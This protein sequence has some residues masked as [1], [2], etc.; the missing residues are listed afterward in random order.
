MIETPP[1]KVCSKCSVEK[2][3]SDYYSRSSNGRKYPESRC[4][5]C[6]I[7]RTMERLK[8]PEY[9]ARH[10]EYTKTA[11]DR[12]HAREKLDRKSGD[13]DRI[14]PHMHKDIKNSDR[15]KGREFD[16]TVDFIAESLKKPCSYCGEENVKMSLDRIDNSLGHLREN[17]LPSCLTCNITRNDMPFDAWLV[18]ATGMKSAREQGLL[19][20]WS[21]SGRRSK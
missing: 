4:K 9:K 8:D 2:P 18:V 10:V 15:K 12:F 5:K 16:L 11:K 6:S 17:V 13:A 7:A 3:L 1:T 19:K 14:A 21:R 20:G